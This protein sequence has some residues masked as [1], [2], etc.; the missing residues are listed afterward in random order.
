MKLMR[1]GGLPLLMA[2]L[3]LT[4]CSTGGGSLPTPEP[5]SVTGYVRDEQGAPIADVLMIAEGQNPMTSTTLSDGSYQLTGLTGP[6]IIRAQKDNWIF[7]EPQ[8][9]DGER[10]DLDFTGRLKTYPLFITVEGKGTVKERLLAS[11][12]GVEYPHG[13]TVELTAWPAPN[14]EFSHWTGD[15][16]GQANPAQITITSETQVTAVFVGGSA[17]LAG[18]IGVEHSFPRSVV[19]VPE[20]AHRPLGESQLS[21]WEADPTEL[22]IAFDPSL[23]EAEQLQVLA[24]LGYEILDRLRVLNAYLVRDSSPDQL[25][26]ISALARPEVQYAEPNARVS[27]LSTVHPTDPRYPDQWHYRLIRLPQA[28]SV[29]T[30]STAIRIAVLDTGI[31]PNHP[32]LARQLDQEYGYNFVQGSRNFA[33]DRGHGTHVA[34]TIG[35]VTNNGLGVAGVLWDV[36]ILPVKV[37]SASGSGTSWALAQGLLYAAGLLDEPG[38]PFNP[39]PAQVINLSLGSP[40]KMGHVD[41]AIDLILRESGCIIVA[42]AG[43]DYG[44]PVYHPAAHP[45]VIAVGAVDSGFGSRPRRTS[46][47][48]YGPELNVMAPGGDGSM[49]GVLSTYTGG[50]YSYM[51]GTSMAAPHVSGVVGLMLASG[52]PPQQVKE[53]LQATSMPLGPQE[54]SPEYGYG[55]INAYW[56]VNGA[57]T[58]RLLVGRREGSEII[59]VREA[60]LPSKGGSFQLQGIPEGEYQVFAWVDVQTG[61]NTLEPGDYF[62]QSLPVHFEDGASYEVLG[63]V[64]ELDADL[65]PAGTALL[66]VQRIN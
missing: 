66:Q 39:R 54:F 23:S 10:S 46:Y 63:T 5:Y 43:N 49:G 51:A 8:T 19:D 47:S 57:D 64:F 14:Y 62:N 38:K 32:D 45:G 52:I 6:T 25:G 65:K 17:N 58:M 7:S 37:L 12:E 53:V 27:V 13:T 16:T 34:G 26:M 4:A 44:A 42:S 40:D 56:A 9:V 15:L 50:S 48:N 59:P 33:D 29:T 36:E 41:N 11:A 22:I 55:L 35:A 61:T 60:A 20:A 18:T 1:P 30:G 31:Q 21:E 3:L 2:L 24:D 28:W